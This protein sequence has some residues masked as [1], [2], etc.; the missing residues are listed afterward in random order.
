MNN[1]INL[2]KTFGNSEY[3]GECVS[4]TTH[5]IQSAYSA[6]NNNEPDFLV[7]ACLLHDIGHFL[8]EDNMNGL[9]VIEHGKV[10]A[11]YLRKLGMNERI[12]CLIENHVKAKKYL[13][14]K[15]K[16]YYDK[17]SS[18]SKQTLEYQGGKMTEKEMEEFEKDINFDYSLKVR[19]YDDIGKN[20][21]QNI[22]KLESYYDLINKYLENSDI[23]ELNIYRSNLKNDGYLLLKDF[24]TKEE[25]E[26]IIQF[27]KELE[28]LPEE[29]GKWM[30]YYE[31]DN[32]NELKSRIENFINYKENIKNFVNK[33]LVPLLNNVC[34]DKM[35][36]FKDKINW[37][38]PNG[39]G[40]K[41][42]QDHPAWSDFD[43]SRFYSVALFCNNSTIENGCLQIVKNMNNI[44]LLQDKGCIPEHIVETLKWEYLETTPCDLLIFDSF[45]PHKSEK[46][47]TNNS[48]SIMYFTFNKLEEGNLYNE[49]VEKKRKYFP[50]PNERTNLNISSKN[51]KYNLGNPLN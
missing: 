14:S 33:K 21:G 28:K 2:Y 45:I 51:N 43:V 35:V 16:D 6:H 34:G 10:G 32:N 4:K 36:L 37:K 27:R 42:H 46:N 23:K 7:L 30:I 8:D 48:R 3:L 22:P 50:P 38:L 24:F 19:Y 39:N 41:A 15:H 26:E 49:Y 5:M 44:G 29:K 18:A 25:S 20:I 40:F 47:N 31:D 1:I 9:G 13:V 11:D 17:L 12:C